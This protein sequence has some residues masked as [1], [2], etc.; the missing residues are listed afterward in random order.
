MERLDSTLA[1]RS[2]HARDEAEATR[3]AGVQSRTPVPAPGRLAALAE[4]ARDNVW[5]PV[6]GKAFGILLLMSGL[7]GIGA[8]STLAEAGQL[9]IDLGVMRSFVELDTKTPPPV[10]KP[11]VQPRPPA[12][13]VADDAADAGP[14]R[15]SAITADGK[16]I[17]NL[18]TVEDL[19]NLPGIGPKRAEQIVAMRDKLKRFRRFTDL[20]RVKGIGPKRL[21]QLLPK[22]VLDP[23]P[24]PDAGAA[25]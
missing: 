7:G 11:E 10:P 5:L 23:P 25:P 13:A 6:A 4:R 9:P 17:L 18:A 14:P 20:L 3:R 21:Q 15:S 16:V 19:R 1:H 2:S 24:Q 8:A 12:S 22:L